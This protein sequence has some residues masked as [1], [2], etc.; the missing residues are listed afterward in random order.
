MQCP[1]LNI[2]SYTKFHLHKVLQYSLLGIHFR[3]HCFIYICFHINYILLTLELN[4]KPCSRAQ[5][6]VI[7]H[8]CGYPTQAPIP[9]RTPLT[10]SHPPPPTQEKG[11]SDEDFHERYNSVVEK[12]R[13]V[14]NT[15]HGRNFDYNPF[16]CFAAVLP[17]CAKCSA[18]GDKEARE[19]AFFCSEFATKLY[20]DIGLLPP[21]VNPQ[22]VS[23]QELISM[24][25]DLEG[26]AKLEDFFED[27]IYVVNPVD[28]ENI[29]RGAPQ[30]EE[31]PDMGDEGKEAEEEE[32]TEEVTK[33][34]E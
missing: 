29:P 10:P 1:V 24:T 25:G 15:Y 3:C 21:D 20:Q 2:T 4:V 30:Q 19:E 26:K 33:E 5:P 13:L 9:P 17:C 6:V 23:P 12:V 22:L 28:V 14:H 7:T 34:E 18:A 8:I 31:A 27:K 16:N 32:K 11:E